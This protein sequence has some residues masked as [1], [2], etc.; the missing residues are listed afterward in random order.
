MSSGMSKVDKMNLMAEAVEGV[1]P[2]L[3][4]K[5]DSY[6]MMYRRGEIDEWM[7]IDNMAKLNR[8]MGKVCR[9]IGDM[10]DP[11]HDLTKGK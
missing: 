10:I 1:R 9:A 6:V 11:H 7:L 8:N 3:R 2:A 5:V 4:S